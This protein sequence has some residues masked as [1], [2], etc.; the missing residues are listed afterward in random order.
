MAV[1]LAKLGSI[2]LVVWPT[3]ECDIKLLYV[4]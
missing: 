2:A 4:A 1:N 3:A